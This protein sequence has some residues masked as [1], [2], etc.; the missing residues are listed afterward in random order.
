MTMNRTAEA[1]FPGRRTAGLR[2]LF[3]PGRPKTAGGTVEGD[4]LV[5]APLGARRRR[6]A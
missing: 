4:E 3:P 2:D 6:V 5:A 1:A